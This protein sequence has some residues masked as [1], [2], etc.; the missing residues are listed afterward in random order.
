MEKGDKV[1]SSIEGYK[2]ISVCVTPHPSLK[3]QPP[4]NNKRDYKSDTLDNT[5]ESHTPDSDVSKKNYASLKRNLYNEIKNSEDDEYI[6]D[7]QLQ[8]FN[9]NS[10]SHENIRKRL[11]LKRF[12]R[13]IIDL[14]LPNIVICE[15]DISAVDY[16]NQTIEKKEK[17][18]HINV[19][20]VES[21]LVANCCMPLLH[22]SK[23]YIWIEELLYAIIT[24]FK[25]LHLD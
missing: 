10:Q 21:M 24:Y 20:S 23:I 3:T 8:N 25:K 19:L 6:D 5:L 14:I 15:K 1:G 13:K 22:I 4:Y 17:W 18:N 16:I 11:L 12:T 9:I 2:K 7:P